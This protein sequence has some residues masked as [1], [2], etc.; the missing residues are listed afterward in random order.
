PTCVLG[1]PLQAIFGFGT[2]GL[3][4]WNRDV[5]SYFPSAGE[6]DTPWRWINA[7]AEPLGQW[8][9]EVRAQLLQ[10]Q[11]IDLLQAPQG[12]EWIHLDG[13]DDDNRRLQAARANPPGDVGSV[14]VLGES[15][16]PPSQQRIASQTPGAVMV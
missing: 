2:D 15:T 1:D 9:L 6:L 13:T 5:L 16:S 11:P 10:G 14:L 7:Q 3:A 4:D 12:V 8:L